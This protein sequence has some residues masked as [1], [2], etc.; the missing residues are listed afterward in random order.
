[1]YESDTI[2]R[3]IFLLRNLLS[4]KLV[5]ISVKLIG[6]SREHFD[7]IKLDGRPLGKIRA[8]DTNAFIIFTFKELKPREEKRVS[9]K[10][11]LRRKKKGSS[12]SLD[13][14]VNEI[15]EKI[16]LRNIRIASFYS[17]R[18]LRKTAARFLGKTHNVLE[19]ESHILDFLQRNIKCREDAPSNPLTIFQRNYG[20]PEDIVFA[21]NVIN[22]LIGLTVRTVS[23]FS[24]IRTG[25]EN[26]IKR[27]VWSEILTPSG[28]VPIDPCKRVV[29]DIDDP[30]YIPIKLESPFRKIRDVETRYK[31]VKT[32][33]R[34][35][36]EVIEEG[37]EI[38]VRSD[39]QLIK[40]KI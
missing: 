33:L 31:T 36:L 17:T 11:I 9:F 22:M 7:I 5:N 32:T 38:I 4:T 14:G 24:I 10:L 18:R 20:S 19:L 2:I 21:F 34:K 12:T 26:I 30:T 13:F 39:G 28:W 8:S 6:F 25:E 37:T 27:W 16:R 35:G 3:R 1:M 23:G 29:L 40:G 15:P